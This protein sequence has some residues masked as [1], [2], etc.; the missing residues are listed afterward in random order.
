MGI[1][2]YLDLATR[3]R[4]L[5]PRAGTTRVI[6][7]DGPAGSGKTAFA[8]RLALAVDG[9]TIHLDDI[10][11]GWSGL[12]QAAPRL[13]E[14]VL[15]PLAEGTG[16]RYRRYDWERNRYA[17]WHEVPEA[18]VLIVEG[19]TSGSK[20]LTP[21]LAFLI[22]VSAPPDLRMARGIERDGGSH[23]ARWEA[24][25]REEDEFFSADGTRERAALCIDGA[26]NVPHDAEREFVTIR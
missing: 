12:V 23:R 3:I 9:P 16:G 19:V 14:W 13:V 21:Y 4:T 1:E 20:I 17:E 18:P 22:W 15:A 11:P 7:V 25:S 24:W 6:A 26:P 10:C 8:A 5:P 2:T